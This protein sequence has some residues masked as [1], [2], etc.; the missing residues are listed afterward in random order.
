[1]KHDEGKL[2]PYSDLP[3]P[4]RVRSRKPNMT[5]PDSARNWALF[6]GVCMQYYVYATKSISGRF[7]IGQTNDASRRLQ[8]HNEKAR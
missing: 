8:E 2:A 1:M 6:F 5:K 4:G 7:S 3:V